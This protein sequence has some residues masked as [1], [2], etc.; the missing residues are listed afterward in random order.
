VH[1]FLTFA[2][3][4]NTGRRPLLSLTLLVGALVMALT[5]SS[6]QPPPLTRVA[7]DELP[8]LHWSSRSASWSTTRTATVASER[9]ASRLARLD[10]AIDSEL[11]ARTPPAASK[12]ANWE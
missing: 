10:L 8:T 11:I 12:T 2:L 5:V 1:G 9:L 7:G 6:S 4:K 3:R